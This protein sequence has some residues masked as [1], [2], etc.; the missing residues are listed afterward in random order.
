MN[1]TPATILVA[2]DD[3][4]TRTFLADELA[5]DGC[6]LLVADTAK[7]ALRLIETKFPDLAV[8][9]V[10]LPDGSG[11]GVIR[12]V[13]T[14][15]AAGSRID[16]QLPMLVLSGR[17]GEHDRLRAFA[18][19]RRR[20]RRQAL[21]LR[22]AARADPR[23]AAPLGGPP[24][25]GRREDRAAGAGPDD[26]RR[27]RRPAARSC[28]RRP[29][30]RCCACWP[31]PRRRSIRRPTCCGRCGASARARRRGPWTP[32][33]AVCGR[34]SASRAPVRHQHLGR[35]LPADR[36]SRDGPGVT[37]LGPLLVVLALAVV[38]TLHGRVVARGLRERAARVAHEVRGPLVGG[39]P[40]AARRG[41]A[42]RGGAGDRRGAGAGAP[43][44]GA[45]AGGPC[46]R[47]VPRRRPARAAGLPGPHLAGRGR[48][49]RGD[50]DARARRRDRGRPRRRAA[51]RPGDEQ[52]PG[53][54]HRARRRRDRR[55][56]PSWPATASAS[57]SPT[58]A[59][60][61]PP[62]S[63]SSRAGRRRA[64]APAA[65]GSRSPP[66]S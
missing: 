15:D 14:A 59:P 12:D 47:P 42:R 4:T 63:P 25:H 31:G 60:A 43:P 13:R 11:L 44:G 45:G 22:G 39:A 1:D 5:A 29:S 62:R 27:P 3:A 34:S 6:E 7:D 53:Q 58:A 23:A 24:A 65:A 66:P 55:R 21:R 33:P 18:R 19:G 38:A 52:R 49:P 8:L 61:C 10:G 32:T 28:S 48:G 64:G 56:A 40:R 9:D 26:P 20:L 50:A 36:R 51:H 16:R 57:R 41:A 46:A 2:E 35:R 37:V 17:S 54:R 30:S